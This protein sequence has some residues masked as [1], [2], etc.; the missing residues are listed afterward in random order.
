ML[1][2]NEITSNLRFFLL[3]FIRGKFSLWNSLFMRIFIFDNV[4]QVDFDERR[5]RSD[6]A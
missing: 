3:K 5:A 4:E 1:R 6:R 2:K